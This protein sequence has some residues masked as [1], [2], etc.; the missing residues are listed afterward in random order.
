MAVG[1][2]RISPGI[3]RPPSEGTPRTSGGL[4][5][6]VLDV[7]CHTEQA[8]LMANHPTSLTHRRTRRPDK[9]TCSDAE[10][11][12]RTWL[13]LSSAAA[14]S[15]LTGVVEPAISTASRDAYPE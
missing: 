9:G 5:P 2:Q 10:L 7:F 13:H 6:A 15:S 1:R 14:V 4:N 12:I 8:P 3:R 11:S